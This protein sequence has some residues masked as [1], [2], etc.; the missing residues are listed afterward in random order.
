[1]NVWVELMHFLLEGLADLGVKGHTFTVTGLRV[2]TRTL[3][4]PEALGSG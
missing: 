2:V 3:R 1:M 4:M